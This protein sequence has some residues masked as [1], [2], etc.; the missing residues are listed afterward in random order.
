MRF[1]SLP[2]SADPYTT[3]FDSTAYP[4]WWNHVVP[5]S[6]PWNCPKLNLRSST[7]DKKVVF[8]PSSNSFVRAP[9][10]SCLRRISPFLDERG[11]L[12]AGGRLE[13]GPFFF[14]TRYPHVLG[15]S[16][17]TE[18]L[19]WG[20]HLSARHS[21]AERTLPEFQHRF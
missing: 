8:P 16:R 6:A 19:M 11:L 20:A 2:G 12:R 13:N 4:F 14:E 15:Y 1:A 21:G 3:K 18:A 5:P 17:I 9:K 7:M 10:D